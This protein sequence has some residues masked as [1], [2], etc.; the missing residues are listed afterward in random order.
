MLT[1]NNTLILSKLT[2]RI[3][4]DTHTSEFAL[5]C[6]WIVLRILFR[7]T[8]KK[9]FH[10]RQYIK[11]FSGIVLIHQGIVDKCKY[12]VTKRSTIWIVLL[13]YVLLLR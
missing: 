12:I 6:I 11:L 3:D 4:T 9:R 2:Q 10:V 8:I 5:A 13:F 1:F 7:L